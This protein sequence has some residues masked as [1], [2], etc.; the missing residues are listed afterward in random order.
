MMKKKIVNH[1]D[2]D[3]CR[4]AFDAAM[5]IFRASNAFPK[6]EQYSL[7]DQIRR[8][9]RSICANLAEGEAAETQ[10][11][12]EFAV[13]CDYLDKDEARALYTTYTEVIA[14]LVAM[15]N[16][17]EQWIITPSRSNNSND[18]QVFQTN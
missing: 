16:H 7:T 5:A 15:I 18:D 2:L 13:N 6:E 10:V 14:I 9:S 17:A 1:Q 12:L 11:R 8:S 3:V 4:K